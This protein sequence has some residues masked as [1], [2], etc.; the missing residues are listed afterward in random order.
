MCISLTSADK[1]EEIT[2]YTTLTVFPRSA[3]SIQD[4]DVPP[5]IVQGP[6]DCTVLIGGDVVLNVAFGGHPKP[7]VTWFKG[8]SWYIYISKYNYVNV[9]HINSYIV[10]VV[11]I[12]V[13]LWFFFLYMSY[14]FHFSGDL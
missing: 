3:A 6:K 4:K 12:C 8:V 5:Y 7:E 13:Y 2:D 1:K 11:W 9:D 14:S 10:N